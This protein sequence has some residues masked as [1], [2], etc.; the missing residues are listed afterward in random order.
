MP[1]YDDTDSFAGGADFRYKNPIDK[2]GVV[3]QFYQVATAKKALDTKTFGSQATFKAFLTSFKDNYKV[4]WNPKE[5]FGRMDA[6]QTYK[7]TQRQIS[8]EFEVPSVS[9]EEAQLN[10][11]NLQSLIQMQYPVYEVIQTSRVVAPA[12]PPINNPPPSNTPP[13]GTPNTTTTPP[14]TTDRDLKAAADKR[15]EQAASA[16]VSNNSVSRFISSP[17]LI[18]VKFL[19][20][21]SGDLNSP[22]AAT[23]DIQ[24][25]LVTVISEVNFNPDLDQ[26]YYMSNDEQLLIPKLFTINLNMTVI[27]TQELGWVNKVAGTNEPL[28]NYQF[29]APVVPE[30]ET[31]GF[32]TYPTYPYQTNN[33]NYFKPEE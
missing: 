9:F 27:H 14:S 8:V 26:G 24:N 28:T 21:I 12:T 15:D 20:W 10:F 25:A 4:N 31:R 7:N 32:V 6:V 33:I 22:T 1:F 5:T 23:S 18:Y 17:P 30:G 19:N 11:L 2:S 16:P 29:G 13:A 3:I